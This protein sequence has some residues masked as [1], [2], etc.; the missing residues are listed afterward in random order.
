MKKV[1][2]IL[3]NILLTIIILVAVAMTFASLNTND[4]GLP[5]IGGYILLNI[6]T[7]SMEPTIKKGDMILTKTVEN[8]DKLQKDDIV[9]FI[10]KEQDTVIIKTHRITMVNNNNGLVSYVTK[11]DANDTV[12]T[13]ELQPLS[14]VSVYDNVRIPLIGAVF[15][16]LSGR[17]GFF[18]FI[19]LPLFVLFVY[20]LYKFI[21]TIVEEKK[22]DLIKRIR[23]EQKRELENK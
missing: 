16:F 15:S 10:A 19:V 5:E 20:Q 11:G 7:G 3:G 21:A 8:I 2:K 4:K 1:F 23:E 6:Q 22:Q 18:L 17:L 13:E 9:S 12:D 14:V